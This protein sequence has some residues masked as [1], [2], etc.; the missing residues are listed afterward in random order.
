MSEM[1]PDMMWY[2]CLDCTRQFT[3]ADMDNGC[4]HCGSGYYKHYDE[5]DELL[6]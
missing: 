2:T 6:Q 1:T 3:L 4:P 5:S